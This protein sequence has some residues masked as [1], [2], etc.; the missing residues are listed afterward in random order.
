MR[1]PLNDCP[2]RWSGQN[3]AQTRHSDPNEKWC[4]TVQRCDRAAGASKCKSD[5]HERHKCTLTN[6]V[7]KS[8]SRWCILLTVLS[9][10]ARGP[11]RALNGCIG[12]CDVMRFDMEP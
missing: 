12:M 7:T 6:T 9:G 2:T 3:G 5:A 10:A 4:V 8:E 11:T 1:Q